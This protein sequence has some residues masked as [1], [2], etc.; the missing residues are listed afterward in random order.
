MSGKRKESKPKEFLTLEELER[1]KERVRK[2][3]QTIYDHVEGTHDGRPNV[4]RTEKGFV[5]SD[6]LLE[7]LIKEHPEKDPAKIK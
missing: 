5:E 1:E 2:M 7:A 6:Q 3:K 4:R